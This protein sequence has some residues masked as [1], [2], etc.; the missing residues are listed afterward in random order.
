MTDGLDVYGG[1]LALLTDLYQLTMACGY[2]KAG[3]ADREAVFHLTFRRA[4]FGG[5]YAV[6]AGIAPAIRFLERLKFSADDVGYLAGLGDSTNAP[7]FPREF[8]DYLGALR[9][10]CDVDAVAEGTL[11]FPHEPLVRVRGPI[12]Q[13]QIVETALL[14]LVNYQTLVATKAARV[15]QAA[16]GAPVLEFGLRRAQGIDGGLGGTRAAY[17]GGVAATS[18]VL[19][20]K[21]FGM[22]VRGTHAHSWVM[23]HSSE[24]DAFRTYAHAMPGNCTLLVDTYDTLTGVRHAIEVGRELRAAGHALGGIRLDSG[25]LAHLSIEAR[26]MLD[27]AGFTDTKIVASNDLDETL[28]GNIIDQ[29]ARIDVWGV[30]TKLVTAYD[31]P[32]LGGI[33]KLGASRDERGAW[34]DAIKLSEQPIKISNPGVL[35]VKRLRKAG[36]LVGDAIYDCERG[37]V[38]PIALHDIEQLA[39]AP[40][41]PSYDSIE[42]LLHPVLRNS[43]RVDAGGDLEEARARCQADLAALS[44][45]SK[46]FLNP[47][48]YVVGLDDHVHARK[49]EL[50]AQARDIEHAR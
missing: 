22:P 10:A 1:S 43:K 2:W 31:Q 34:R 28:I 16:R 9:F 17:I 26:R 8:L 27:A 18:N 29:G 23:F 6:A 40:I 21:L 24:L 20:G 33:Y 25:D 5:A 30:G 19:A 44:P 47:Q 48:P 13:A 37:L 7:L 38:E 3:V 46:R 12:L 11:V 35:G 4:P 32:A 15:C 41:V 49:L 36:A 42:D 39:Q 50:I 14:T 45:R